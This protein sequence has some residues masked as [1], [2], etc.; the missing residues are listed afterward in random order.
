LNR[1]ENNSK[2]IFE[3]LSA[4]KY[5]VIRKP[6]KK[7]GKPDDEPWCSLDVPTTAEIL[8]IRDNISNLAANYYTPAD[9][10]KVFT[11]V[12]YENVTY[13]DAEVKNL[14]NEHINRMERNLQVLKQFIDDGIHYNT[15]G[16]F[17]EGGKLQDCT[18]GML[19]ECTYEQMRKG[20][21]YP[22]FL[23]DPEPQNTQN[24]LESEGDS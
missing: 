21:N 16:D 1:I 9:Y 18:Y 2:L 3:C 14:T 23:A 10:E 19:S 12:V 4:L 6:R 24:L 15:W 17:L 5:N 8:R 22:A 13:E 20:L 11:P 7:A